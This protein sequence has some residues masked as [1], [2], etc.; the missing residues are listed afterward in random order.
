M[1]EI[2][3]RPIMLQEFASMVGQDLL[4]DCDPQ[5]IKLRLVEAAPLRSTDADT[6]PSFLV[7][8]RSTPEQL[9]VDGTYTMRRGDFG[10]AEIFIS[11]LAPPRGAEAGYY[12]Q[13]IF[14]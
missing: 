13:A 2:L 7:V 3:P 12:Y 9:L 10:P 14:N 4:V 8:F 6:A 11:S 5:P 1:P